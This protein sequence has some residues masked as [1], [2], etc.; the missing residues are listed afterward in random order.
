M[1]SSSTTSTVTASAPRAAL[2]TGG[3]RGIG[4]AIALRLAEAGADVAITYVRDEEAARAV[5]AKIE[6][7]GRRAVALR[8]DAADAG[9]AAGAV[10]RAADALGRLDVLVNNAGIGVLG[11]IAELPDAEID[12]VMAVNV[13]A[14]FLACRAAADRMADGG[15]VISI[16]TALSRYVGG[17]GS[18]LY[19]MSKSALIGL[20]KPLARELGPRGITVNLVQPGP[21]DTDLNP[22]AGPFAEGQRVATALGRFGTADEVASLVAY[23]ASADAGFITGTEVV[24]DGGHAA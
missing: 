9:A 23:L 20:T 24:V 22:A 16:G 19:A 13:R 5:V 6:G 14:V 17:P 11:P 12:R 21:V 4:A 3:S 7:V 1:S 10:H 18:T 8:C 2:V 15:R